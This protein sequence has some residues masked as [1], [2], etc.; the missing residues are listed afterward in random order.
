MARYL[1]EAIARVKAQAHAAPSRL[2]VDVD[3][4]ARDAGHDW[5]DRKLTPAVTVR[6][7]ILQIL[8]GNVAIT[9]LN[10]LGAITMQASSYCAARM[11]LPMQVFT[12]L[13]DAVSQAV[14]P[15]RLGSAVGLLNGRRVLLADATTFS[16]PDT[17]AL[18]AHFGYPSGQRDGCGFPMGKLLG[19]IDAITGAI[20]VAMACPLFAHEGRQMLT[21]H[22]L[23]RRG[24][25]LVADRAFCSYLQI[26]ML[27]RQGVDVVMR[28]QQRRPTEAMADTLQTWTRPRRCPDGVSESIWN[29]L[30]AEL[31]VRVV[32]YVVNRKG[33]RT[34]NVYVATTLLDA[35][36][37]P[38]ETV[39]RLYGHRWNIETCFNQL[40]THAK[41]NTLRCQTV[42]GAIKELLV[43]LI[44]WNLVRM[45]MARFAEQAGISPWRISFTDT[46]RCL[47]VLLQAPARQEV[48]L[49]INPDRPD[50]WEPRKLKRRIKEYDLLTESR[51]RL[52][53]KQEAR[54]A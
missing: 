35:R 23:L 4:L 12:Q 24:D 52:K 54:C 16:T 13:F 15:V 41:M 6:L 31:T 47:A 9:A 25:V 7:F 3:Q 44:V 34:R 39:A 1:R 36:A 21:L 48:Q 8:H 42:E 46:L 2:P 49:R 27:V 53:A 19:V 5:R 11:R 32:R 18:R 20:V 43:Y 30:P 14:E 37:F 38:P 10:H 40:K 28:L 29:T 45:T 17:P 26:A 22:P 33:C 50:R 51:Q